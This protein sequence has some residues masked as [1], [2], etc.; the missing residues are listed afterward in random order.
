M[1]K[2]PLISKFLALQ[3]IDQAN[4]EDLESTNDSTEK[5]STARRG[6]VYVGVRAAPAHPHIPFPTT[7]G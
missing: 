3:I 6:P 4:F 5:S 1:M 2:P 7:R